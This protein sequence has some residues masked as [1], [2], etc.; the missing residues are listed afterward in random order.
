MSVIDLINGSK[1]TAFSF[2][3]LPPLKGT[4]VEKL[5]RQIDRLLE[6]DPKY[7]NI[8]T[9]HSEF[10][11]RT[12][13]SGQVVKQNIRKRPGTVA[14]A[15]EIQKKYGI[16][17]VPHII[18]AGFSRAETEYALVDLQILGIHDLLVLQ[19]DKGKL[20][21]N[22]IPENESNQ[23]ASDLQRQINRYNEGFFDDG[24]EMAMKPQ[25]PFTYGVAGYPEKHADA[26]SMDSDIFYLKEKVKAGADYIVTQMFFDNQKYFEF[27]ARCRAEGITVPI[28][29]GI[30]PIQ[31]MNQLT[32]LPRIFGSSIPEPFAA[33]LAKCTTDEEAK[34][35]GI[36][37]CTEQCKELIASGVPSLH[38]YTLMATDSVAQVAKAIY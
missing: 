21:P 10:V 19:G 6:F 33:E 38:F 22:F 12:L 35:V 26:P 1:R 29:P 16:A 15:A 30:K 8:T 2:E 25:I 4:G 23:Y 20:E 28:I 37:W 27:V 17:T 9:H 14:I 7:I 36:E 3:L 11:E 18:C 34:Q 5:Y 13:S 31:L 24:S 32:V